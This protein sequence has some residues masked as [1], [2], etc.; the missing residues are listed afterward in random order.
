VTDS[1]DRSEPDHLL[2]SISP[3][4]LIRLIHESDAEPEEKVDIVFN[5]LKKCKDPEVTARLFLG[6]RDTILADPD[7]RS[8]AITAHMI[9]T[10][11][12]Q[13]GVLSERVA[14]EAVANVLS[15]A[16]MLIEP[17]S[18]DSAQELM[19]WSRRMEHMVE[20]LPERSGQVCAH[21]GDKRSDMFAVMDGFI[22]CLT[23]SDG[24]ASCY[25]RVHDYGE[26]LGSGKGET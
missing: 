4:H 18:G 2:S 10:L 24:S 3:E 9:S 14:I 22:L 19:D 16:A 7:A 26:P 13:S 17:M 1:P 8:H 20:L 15:L 21:C 6:L 12:F 25:T 23:T 5:A 11:E